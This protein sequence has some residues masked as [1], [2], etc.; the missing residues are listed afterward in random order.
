MF[1]NRESAAAFENIF[2]SWES[3]GTP[4]QG[5]KKRNK[6]MENYFLKYFIFT[7]ICL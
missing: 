6:D 4:T 7:T 1:D 5:L 3:S 2:F